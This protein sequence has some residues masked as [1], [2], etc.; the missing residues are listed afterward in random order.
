MP[1]IC[2]DCRYVGPRPSGIGEVVRGLIDHLPALA[3]DFRFRLLRNPAH[4]GPLSEAANVSEQ[5]VSQAANGPA[6]MWWLPRVADLTGVDLFHA[7]FNT[8][9][10]GLAMPR[11]VTVHDVMRL[12]HPRWCRTG[13][14]GAVEAAFYGHGLRRAIRS[15]DAIAAVSGATARAIADWHPAA[16]ARTAVTLSGVSPRFRPGDANPAVLAALGLSPGR[17]FVLTVGQNAPYKNQAGAVRAFALAYAGDPAFELVIVQRQ[18]AGSRALA[19]LARGLGIG[20]RVRFLR[21]VD[22]EALVTLYRAARVLLHPS[23][24]EGFGNPVAEA[25]ACGCPVVTSDVSAMPEVAGGAA[26]L[27]DPHD[28]A[29][30]AAGLIAVTRDSAQAASMREAGIVRAGELQ[31]RDFAAANLAIYR[32]VLARRPVQHFRQRFSDARSVNNGT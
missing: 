8:L 31:W 13:I 9:P 11:V 30:I 1:T 26:L 15:A 6:T 2:I 7:T 27:A 14:R 29:S 5:V 18:G 12:T 24:A 10:A 20:D 17:P 22:G 3:P 23:F 32:R 4:R 16:A 19:R 28:A 21:A 25:M